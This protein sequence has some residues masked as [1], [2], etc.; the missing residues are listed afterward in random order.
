MNLSLTVNSFKDVLSN[1]LLLQVIAGVDGIDDRQGYGVPLP[2]QIPKYHSLLLAMRRAKTLLVMADN[3]LPTGAQAQASDLTAT[4]EGVRKMKIGILKESGETTGMDP[5]VFEC[6]K[7][8]AKK[9]EEL[10]AEVY[11]ISVP[12]HLVAPL[13][14]RVHRYG[15]F[16]LALSFSILRSVKI[17][18]NPSPPR[19][20]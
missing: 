17:Y 5:R 12:S 7:N 15:T 13:V 9:F 4:H 18:P 16:Y 19:E 1:A 8:A 11:E 14:G 20:S 6:V 2:S 3:S 10:G